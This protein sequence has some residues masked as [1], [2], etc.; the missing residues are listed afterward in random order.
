VFLLHARADAGSQPPRLG[1]TAS[2]RVGNAPT[3]NRAK[4]VVRE[5][6]RALRAIFGAGIDVVVIVRRF[7]PGSGLDDVIREWFGAQ[8]A[9]ARQCRRANESRRA[10]EGQRA[11][12]ESQRPEESRSQD[13]SETHGPSKGHGEGVSV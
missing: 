3:R 10:N 7:R 9:I 11:E 6:F 4:R 5:A 8:E 13:D 1:I 2:R 12:E